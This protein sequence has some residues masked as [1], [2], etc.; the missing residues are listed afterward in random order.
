MKV[1]AGDIGGTNSRLAI[2]DMDG[3]DGRARAKPIFEQTYPSAAH[4]SLDVIAESFLDAAAS[5]ARR[6]TPKIESACFGIAGPIE[7]N[8][9]RATNLP[10]VVDGRALSQ[11]LAIPR[12]QL[13]NDFHAAALGVTAVRPDELVAL[14]GG[15]PV[16]ARTD[17]G[18][19]RRHRP[20]PGVPALVAAREPLP[21][22]AVRRGPRRP[23]GAHAARARAGR[24]S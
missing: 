2:Y 20:R 9:C 11:R 10:W 6:P 8:I 16:D 19:R 12:V 21:G 13:V 15:P 14:G 1:L 22:R 3:V 5:E 17:R 24:S 23:G 18:A 4:P 7:N